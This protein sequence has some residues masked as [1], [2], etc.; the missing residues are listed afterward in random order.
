MQG[1]T[2]PV[3]P[4]RVEDRSADFYLEGAKNF[5][6]GISRGLDGMGARMDKN[7]AEK[8]RKEELAGAALGRFQVLRQARPDVVEPYA[9]KFFGGSLGAQQGILNELDAQLART[10]RQGENDRNYNFKVAQAG[11]TNRQEDERIRN[12]AEYQRGVIANQEADNK[13]QQRYLNWQMQPDNQTP[14]YEQMPDGTTAVGVKGTKSGTRFFNFLPQKPDP[15]APLKT[16]GQVTS[17]GYPGDTTTETNSLAGIGAWVSGDDAAKIKA[18][19][20]SPFKLMP[21]DLAVSPDV[22]AQFRKA[23]IQPG[24]DVSVIREDGSEFLTRW[25]DRTS[26]AL[27]GRYDFYSPGGPLKD[28]GAPIVGVRKM[29]SERNP[30]LQKKPA[31]TASNRVQTATVK[32][33]DGGE[34]LVERG[35]DGSWK[36]VQ[37]QGEG[38]QSGQNP[39]LWERMSQM[40]SGSSSPSSSAAPAPV[41]KL[42]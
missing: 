11:I 36:P 7:K 24:D 31:S 20:D 29:G 5:G 34:Q 40:V 15:M 42:W 33:P 28:N 1:Y 25:M 3:M 8:M 35:A 41:K 23:G 2:G 9:D 18:G 32:L 16:K 37:V 21:G 14:L 27:T 13:R 30:Y 12:S 26:G 17:Y 10:D 22:E 39:T 19:Q 6:E 4:R 38:A